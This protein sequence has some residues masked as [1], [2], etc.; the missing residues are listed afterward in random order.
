MIIT[1][2]ELDTIVDSVYNGQ[3]KQAKEQTLRGCR[4]K[5]AKLAYRVATV[6]KLLCTRDDWFECSR[7]ISM[8]EE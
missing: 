4:T 2:N 6:V 1:Q 7:F 5:P 3:M 8:F